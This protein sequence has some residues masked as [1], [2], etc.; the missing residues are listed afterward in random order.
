[1]EFFRI[2]NESEIADDD[3][4]V[5]NYSEFTELLGMC[6]LEASKRDPS[7]SPAEKVDWFINYMFSDESFG[8][9]RSLYFD[10]YVSRVQ[11]QHMPSK[12]F[13]EM[14]SYQQPPHAYGWMGIDSFLQSS[15]QKPSKSFQSDEKSSA[16]K[17]SFA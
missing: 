14:V 17:H 8:K 9:I 15:S 4:E 6:A 2:V 16:A 12:N 13:T 11:I 7:M 3:K 5:L 1:V 10:R